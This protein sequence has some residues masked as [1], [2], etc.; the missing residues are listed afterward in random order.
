M[1]PPSS[2]PP[3]FGRQSPPGLRRLRT[4]LVL[5]LGSLGLL[6]GVAAPSALAA[7]GQI[8]IQSNDAPPL[9]KAHPTGTPSR[10]T[11]NF[12]CSTVGTQTCGDDPVIRVPFALT[13]PIDPATPDMDTWLF[14]TSS[15]ISGLILSTEIVGGELVIHLDPTK[16]NPG[17]SQTIQLAI[18]PPNNVTPDQ[19]TWS[20]D[21]T[22]ETDDLP[23]VAAPAPA[24]G[25]RSLGAL[26]P[27]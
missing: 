17:D 16:V 14:Q 10:Y 22:F 11:I 13:A 25:P 24:L 4:L 9:P 15:S 18:T 8:T 26:G 12:E 2:S 3:R 27:S 21:A 7:T 19:T 1:T 23:E 5:L 20:L 6:A